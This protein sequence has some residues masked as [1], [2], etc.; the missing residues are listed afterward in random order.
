MNVS[1]FLSRGADPTLKSLDNPYVPVV[2]AVQ[3]VSQLKRFVNKIKQG[4]EA[5][6]KPDYVNPEQPYLKDLE[7]DEEMDTSIPAIL[8][9]VAVLVAVLSTAGTILIVAG[10]LAWYS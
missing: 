7:V 10:R 3:I 2:G 5:K 9:R 8:K 6:V 4:P 1:Y